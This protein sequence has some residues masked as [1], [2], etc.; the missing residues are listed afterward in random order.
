LWNKEQTVKTYDQ[1]TIDAAGAFLVGELE[2]LDKTLHLPLVNTTW[3]RDI[4]LRSDVS[5][6]DEVSSFTNSAFAAPGGINPSGKNWISGSA[7]EIPGIALDIK[8]TTVPMRLWGLALAWTLVELAKA[9]QIGRPLDTQKYEGMK[10]KYGMDVDEMVYV[11]DADLGAAGLL[12]NPKIAPENAPGAW[13]GADPDEILAGIDEII[14]QGWEKSAYAVCPARLLLPPQQYS[15]LTRPVTAAGSKSILTY[16]AEECV[17]NGIN[18]KPLEI[19][20]VKWLKGLGAGNTNRA[21]AYTKNELFV[22]FPLVPLQH[23]PVEYRGLA[24]I[25]TYFGTLG[26]VEFV[27]PETVAYMDGI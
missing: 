7:T 18:G 20:P 24:Q 3:G 1:R 8:K 14:N 22:R 19:F 15:M 17:A 6:A 16:V 27:Y 25:T 21:V 9:E 13:A 12:N 5:I 11:G 2:R 4:D 26:E 10:M 23:T